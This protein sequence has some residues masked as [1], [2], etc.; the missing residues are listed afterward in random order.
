MTTFLDVPFRAKDE[1]KSLGARWDAVARKWF[2]PAGRDLAPFQAWLPVN[3]EMF[4]PTLP[5]SLDVAVVSRGVTLSTL[6]NGVAQAVADA[7]GAGIWTIVEIVEARSRNGHVYLEVSERD[8][9]GTVLAKANAVIWANTA[10]KILPAFEQATGASLAP[11]I[12]LLVRARPV[13]KPQYGFSLE[14]DAIDP[15]YTL[16]DLEARKREIRMR[17][18]QEGIFEKNRHLPAPWDFN[19][20]LVIAPQGAAGL[21]D[22]QSEANRLSQC[23]VCHFVYA[24]CRFQGEGAAAEICQTLADALSAWGKN[25][26]IQP[27]AVVVIRGGGAVNDLAW[28]NDYALAKTLCKFE[29]PVFTGI[30][31]ERDS[32]ILD[33]IAHTSFDTP[34]KVILGIEQSIRRRID[35]AKNNFALLAYT[36]T[37]TLDG[38]KTQTGQHFSA[39]LE[40]AGLAIVQGREKI[41]ERM[42]A[43]GDLA[44]HQIS[45]ARESSTGLFR[46]IAGQGPEKTL[47][48]GFA[49]VRD[50]QGNVVS[51]GAS[52]SENVLLSV[53]FHDATF[54]VDVRKIC[55][56]I[57]P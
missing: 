46:E 41:S 7:F 56:E 20:V 31:H 17:L 38:L 57:K 35:E 22:F 23:G 43:I 2:V 10:S 55:Q 27:D 32:C 3:L 13:Y 36:A 9:T 39:I 19:A 52:V 50:A 24:T 29:I 6:L 18:T 40:R 4:P 45:H 21:G 44:R 16:G 26:P 49:I 33:E 14:I 25:Y 37:R 12:K 28:L 5:E 51:S 1:A 15:E 30:G 54:N 8:A 47:R 42:E 53:Q 34:S 11:G 48:R